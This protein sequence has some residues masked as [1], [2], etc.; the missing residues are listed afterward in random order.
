MLVKIPELRPVVEAL[1]R[2]LPCN[3]P[4]RSGPAEIDMVAR[5]IRE[6][7]QVDGALMI[8]ATIVNRG[9]YVQVWPLFQVTFTNI[10]GTTIAMRQ[11]QPDEYL[12]P[13]IE[14]AKGMQPG[15]EVALMLE[16]MDPGEQATSFQF[17]FL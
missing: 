10:S 7:P 12:A 14:L 2:S 13:G 1:C 8:S 17:D 15:K 6:H 9:S 3:L 16:V 5:E 4:L 11:F